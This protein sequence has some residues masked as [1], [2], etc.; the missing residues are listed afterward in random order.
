MRKSA[1][2]RKERA[3]SELL[4][5][6]NSAAPFERLRSP[7]KKADSIN[8][9]IETPDKENAQFEAGIRIQ[10]ADEDPDYHEMG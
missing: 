3:A 10:M 7:Y 9:K 1:G 6:W 2:T 8:L 5:N 4:G